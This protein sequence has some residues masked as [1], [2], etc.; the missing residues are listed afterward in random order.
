MDQKKKATGFWTK[1]RM[2]LI[3]VGIA[4]AVPLIPGIVGAWFSWSG[5]DPVVNLGNGDSMS[6]TVE[7]Q[8]YV[9][10]HA[11]KDIDI[12]VQLPQGYKGAKLA[13]ESSFTYFCYD[14]P[15]NTLTTRTRLIAVGNGNGVD[16]NR[17]G[18][19][20]KARV[21]V[22]IDS[23]ETGPVCVIVAVGKTSK[24]GA[25][26]YQGVQSGSCPVPDPKTG[27]TVTTLEGTSDKPVTGW[28]KLG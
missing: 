27:V 21:A 11:D 18:Q 28:I 26:S 3:P 9:A 4:A 25:L 12:Q 6:I 14:L 1:R 20:N 15:S 5:V 16:N 8:R 24:V 23:T 22:K 17:S 10:C 19:D 2:L 13:S 7:M